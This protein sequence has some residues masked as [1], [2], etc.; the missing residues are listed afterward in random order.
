M[1]WLD[2]GTCILITDPAM[3][4]VTVVGWVSLSTRIASHGWTCEH[5]WSAENPKY[6]PLLALQRREIRPD[7]MPEINLFALQTYAQIRIHRN[8][9]NTNSTSKNSI[10]FCVASVRGKENAEWLVMIPSPTFDWNFEN[11]CSIRLLSL[12][13]DWE[14]NLGSTRM[15]Y[16]TEL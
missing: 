3:K 6:G 7:W 9:A 12:Q 8:H 16:R 14:N 1:Q 5:L 4:L 15:W 10:L 11:M 13:W 2:G